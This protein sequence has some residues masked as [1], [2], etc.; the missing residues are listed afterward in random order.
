MAR[1]WRTTARRSPQ[2]RG[3]RWPNGWT[4]ASAPTGLLRRPSPF[5]PPYGGW[6]SRTAIA[7]QKLRAGDILVLADETPTRALRIEAKITAG[8]ALLKLRHY[9]F[10]LEQFEA[11]LELDPSCKRAREKK[12]VCL[13]RLGRYEEARELVRR[14]T[15]DYPVDPEVWALLGRVEKDNWIGRWRREGASS[16]ELR[17]AASGEWWIRCRHGAAITRLT[18]SLRSTNRRS[19]G[20]LSGRCCRA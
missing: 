2:W 19:V 12:A 7:R 15:E 8:E 13:G 5:N 6:R 14:L 16:A 20:P 11:A 3:Q 17:A 4:S 9:D 18:T 10:A 1:G